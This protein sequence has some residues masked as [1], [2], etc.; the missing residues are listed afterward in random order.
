[1]K[2]G[3]H[4]FVEIDCFAQL[5]AQEIK[6]YSHNRWQVDYRLVIIGLIKSGGSLGRAVASL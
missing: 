5:L 4:F 2:Q 3:G 1:L 6:V